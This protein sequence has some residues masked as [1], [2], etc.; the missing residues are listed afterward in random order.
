MNKKY[1]INGRK[2]DREIYRITK[3][4]GFFGGNW[5]SHLKLIYN[6]I[7]KSQTKYNNLKH[8]EILDDA[9]VKIPFKKIKCFSRKL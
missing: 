3:H 5:M 7:Q 9:G 2:A 4:C 1:V 8:S 6:R